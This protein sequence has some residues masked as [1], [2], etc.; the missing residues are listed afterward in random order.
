[1]PREVGL[2]SNHIAN[3]QESLK[4]SWNDQHMVALDKGDVLF[5]LIVQSYCK[6]DLQIRD[7]YMANKLYVG[8]KLKTYSIELIGGLDSVEQ[9]VLYEFAKPS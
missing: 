6:L 8:D 9:V 7:D 5:S 3:D 4:F 1:M 2:S